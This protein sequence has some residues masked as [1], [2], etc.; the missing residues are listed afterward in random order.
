MQSGPLDIEPA[1]AP[2]SSPLPCAP[3]R[4]VWRTPQGLPRLTTPQSL[5]LPGRHLWL[6]ARRWVARWRRAWR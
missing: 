6:R 4:T 3:P 1:L 5:G 2:L